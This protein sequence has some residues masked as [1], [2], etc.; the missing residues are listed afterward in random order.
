MSAEKKN[1]RR[2]DG[3]GPF[4]S[5]EEIE[6][7]LN[8]IMR[9]AYADKKCRPR[10]SVISAKFRSDGEP[11]IEK[12]CGAGERSWHPQIMSQAE[13]LVDV[14]DNE[15]EVVVVAELPSVRKEDIELSGTS[16][17]LRMSVDDS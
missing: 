12:V 14:S 8:L 2:R 11:R 16:E 4:F 7:I 13:F 15:E 6:K 1:R 17:V 5:V 3:F 9:Q 10:L